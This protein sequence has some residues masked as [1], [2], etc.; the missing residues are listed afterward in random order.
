MEF[1][2][3]IGLRRFDVE[4]AT[5][6]SAL[7]AQ[8]NNKLLCPFIVRSSF[9]LASSQTVNVPSSAPET[10]NEPSALKAQSCT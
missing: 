5:L 9:P 10:A 7:N 2:H 6:P 4:A 3:N 1:L 8:P